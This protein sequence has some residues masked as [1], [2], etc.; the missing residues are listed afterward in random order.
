MKLLEVKDNSAGMYEVFRVGRSNSEGYCVC[1]TEKSL[2]AGGFGLAS[3]CLLFYS[4]VWSFEA[5]GQRIS[6]VL[7]LFC[8]LLCCWWVNAHAFGFV[9]HFSPIYLWSAAFGLWLPFC[10]CKTNAFVPSS[11]RLCPVFQFG[12]VKESEAPIAGFHIDRSR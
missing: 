1:V 4:S 11:V 7:Y 3:V 5:F 12:F 8:C 10:Y 6:L 2:S 9:S